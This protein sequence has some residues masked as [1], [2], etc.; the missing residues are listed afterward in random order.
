MAQAQAQKAAKMTKEQEE[1]SQKKLDELEQEELRANQARLM[2]L[3][4]DQD[5]QS[6][7]KKG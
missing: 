2:A 7:K 6:S 3:L 1:A 4:M 5:E